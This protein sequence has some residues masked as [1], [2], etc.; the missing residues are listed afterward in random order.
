MDEI[1]F[2]VPG[3]PVGKQRPRVVRSGGASIAYTPQ[4]TVLYENLVKVMYQQA[5]GNRRFS[6]D[7]MLEMRIA[8]YYQ[9]P[10]SDSKKLRERKLSGELRPTKKPDND[11]ILKVI[12]DALNGVAYRDDAQIVECRCSKYYAEVPL[13]DVAIREIKTGDDGE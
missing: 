2:M 13:V 4:K 8:A 9:V 11:N 1:R 7:S 6:D 12:E 3:V 5:S 10:K